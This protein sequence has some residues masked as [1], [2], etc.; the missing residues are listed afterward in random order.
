M[1]I[2][3]IL[4]TREGTS[5]GADRTTAEQKK[6]IYK[7]IADL[8]FDVM[9]KPRE[10]TTVIFHEHEIEDLGQ[11]ALPLAAYRRERAR[12]RQTAG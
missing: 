7:G 3:N 11:G 1:P 6:A 8:L 5:P 10:D 4:V 12:S 9:G 2:V